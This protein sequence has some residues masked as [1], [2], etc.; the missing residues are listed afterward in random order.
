MRNRSQLVRRVVAVVGGLGLAAGAVG[1][2]GALQAN[3]ATTQQAGTQQATAAV[4]PVVKKT[5]T[6]EASDW[7]LP[8]GAKVRYYG[9][10]TGIAKNAVVQV[11]R[12]EGT[13]W[14]N[15]PA[16][17]KVTSTGAYSVYVKSGRIGKQQFRVVVSGLVSKTAYLTI[18]KK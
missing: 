2:A 7:I 18:T 8:V 9:K 10:T 13:K 12:L 15:F 3:A 11:Q 5:V 14:K 17:T 1:V 4:K 16:T 6:L